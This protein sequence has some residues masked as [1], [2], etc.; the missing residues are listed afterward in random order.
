MLGQ[1]PH[2]GSLLPSLDV[3]SV[4]KIGGPPWEHDLHVVSFVL[5][6]AQQFI[7]RHNSACLSM[8]KINSSRLRD[9]SPELY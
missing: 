3:T 6:L 9:L 5:S 4:I 2:H 8:Q 7:E 1:Q